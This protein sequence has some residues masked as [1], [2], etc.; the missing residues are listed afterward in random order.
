MGPVI[1]FLGRCATGAGFIALGADAL[2]FAESAGRSPYTL[3]WVGAHLALDETM[4]VVA[5]ATGAG[6]PF[7][8]L[9]VSLALLWIGAMALVLAGRRAL[10]P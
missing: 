3:S 5:A 2:A 9:P 4:P 6:S 10:K 1:R 7:G 8:A